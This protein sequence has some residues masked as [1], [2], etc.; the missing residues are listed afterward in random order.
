MPVGSKSEADP[1]SELCG[2]K[3]D[4]RVNSQIS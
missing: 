2:Q 1:V 3:R 4:S